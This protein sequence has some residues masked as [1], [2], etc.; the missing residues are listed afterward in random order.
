MERH[1]R[2]AI[3]GA[4]GM[5][6]TALGRYLGH[7]GDDVV[8]FVRPDSRTS[9]TPTIKWDPRSGYLDSDDL[10]HH[11]PFD[12]IVHLAGAGIGEHR[13]NHHRRTEILNSRV[14]STNLLVEGLS[15]LNP[16]P[17]LLSA[18]A[19]GFYG[20]RGEDT[21]S[22]SASRG[23]G[24]LADVCHQWEQSALRYEEFH[25]SVGLMR[26]G[27]VLDRS[28]GALARQLPLFR[29]GL[30]GRLGSGLQWLSPISLSD[31]VRALAH[32]VEHALTGPINLT[33]PEPI[34]NGEFTRELAHLVHRPALFPAPTWALRLALGTQMAD[35]LI[36]SSQRV[37]PDRL[38]DSGF[39][40]AHR[41]VREILAHAL[42]SPLTPTL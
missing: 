12:A 33:A 22:E 2:V 29:L 36:L 41:N 19:I 13:W 20:S 23:S 18:S 35:E 42:A 26:T 9:Q 31:H 40:F 39:T 10:R 1:V 5:I 6:G 37:R 30:G 17:F 32:I 27:I 3:T 25:G 14:R 15:E 24:F 16:R 21:L 4:S 38:L 11:G 8:T 7:R 28:G 34:R